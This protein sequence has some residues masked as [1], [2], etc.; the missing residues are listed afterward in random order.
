ME[1]A[2]CVRQT[3]A[4]AKAL[5]Q[6]ECGNLEELQMCSVWMEYNTASVKHREK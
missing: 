5:R 6:G 1:E 2:V 4:C 3:E